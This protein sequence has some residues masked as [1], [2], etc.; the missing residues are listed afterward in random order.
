MHCCE[1]CHV[2]RCTCV[3]V[4]WHGYR[5]CCQNPSALLPLPSVFDDDADDEF[6]DEPDLKPDFEPKSR[7]PPLVSSHPALPSSQGAVAWDIR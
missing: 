6:D 3:I 7:L 5:M 1:V 4:E 2:H